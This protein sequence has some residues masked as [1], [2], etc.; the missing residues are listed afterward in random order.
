MFF[1]SKARKEPVTENSSMRNSKSLDTIMSRAARM[2]ISSSTGSGMSKSKSTGKIISTDM[3]TSMSISTVA[4]LNKSVS[5]NMNGDAI[6]NTNEVTFENEE[7]KEER[8][9]GKIDTT[10]SHM[11]PILCCFCF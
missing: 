5:M 11:G 4:S 3:S 6:E 2:S 10:Q 1:R 9:N 7:E 8:K